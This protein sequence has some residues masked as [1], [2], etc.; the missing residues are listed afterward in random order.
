MWP[1]HLAVPKSLGTLGC[2]GAP[3]GIRT[4]DLLIRSQL[5][6]PLSYGRE[7]YAQTKLISHR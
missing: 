7:I 3:G 1:Q 6:Y 4:P 5:L 2:S